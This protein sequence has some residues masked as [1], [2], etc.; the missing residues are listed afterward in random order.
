[1]HWGIKLI[2]NRL[3]MYT[4][5]LSKFTLYISHEKVQYIHE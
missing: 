4:E 1:M 3:T 5:T 2:Q